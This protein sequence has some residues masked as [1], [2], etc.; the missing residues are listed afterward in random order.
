MFF[1]V[2]SISIL[3][4]WYDGMLKVYA[5][6]SWGAEFLFYIDKKEGEYLKS[7]QKF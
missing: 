1:T 4:Y 7:I 6:K 3:S 5:I 2:L